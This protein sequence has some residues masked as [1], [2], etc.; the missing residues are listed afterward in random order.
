MKIKATNIKPIVKHYTVEIDEKH[1]FHIGLY[2]DTPLIKPH[3][4]V[5]LS[6]Q[7]VDYNADDLNEAI[8]KA[9]YER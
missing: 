7:P 2:E 4:I 8:C 1:T 3:Q 5:F 6:G 9:F